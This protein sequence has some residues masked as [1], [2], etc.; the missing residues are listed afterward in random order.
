MK[1]VLAPNEFAGFSFKNKK[2]CR[3]FLKDVTKRLKNVPSKATD[4][5][6]VFKVEGIEPSKIIKGD[7]RK[8][9]FP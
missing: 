6:F 5:E 3:A 2:E 8:Q 9:E 1:I 7:P 4:F